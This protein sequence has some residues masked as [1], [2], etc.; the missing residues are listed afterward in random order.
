MKAQPRKLTAFRLSETETKKLEHLA[1]E[2]GCNKSEVI[3][4]LINRSYAA[5]VR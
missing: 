3:R 4:Q 5:V 1:H 2:R